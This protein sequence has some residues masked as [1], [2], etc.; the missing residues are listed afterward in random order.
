MDTPMSAPAK[1][2]FEQP[3]AAVQMSPM[4]APPS[5][6]QQPE[7][8]KATRIRGGGAAKDCFIGLVGCFLCFEC[9]EGCCDCI[10]GILCCPCEMCC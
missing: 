5:Q 4:G 6:G 8:Q 10:G 3:Q 9:C 2:T 7:R 1:S